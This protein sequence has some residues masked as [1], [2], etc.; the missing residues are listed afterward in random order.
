LESNR[1][2]LVTGLGNPGNDYSTTR[3]N[4]GFMVIDELSNHFSIPIDREKFGAC[5]G[6]GLVKNRKVILAKPMKY[7]NRSGLPVRQ[8]AD[9]FRISGKDLVI[10]HDDIDLAF[11]RIKIIEKGGHG[12]HRGIKSLIECFGGGDLIRL[13]VGVGRPGPKI[14]AADHVLGEFNPEEKEMLPEIVKKAR[15]AVV[16][17]LCSGAKESMNVFNRKTS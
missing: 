11:G 13:R 7:M 8:I 16:S 6:R 4:I 15:D 14:E 3:H 12:G 2:Y 1:L 9:Y 5:L 10:I 17:I